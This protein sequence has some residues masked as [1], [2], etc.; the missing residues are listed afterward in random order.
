MKNIFVIVLLLLGS[1]PSQGWAEK[2]T[3]VVGVENI[4]HYPHYALKDTQWVGL[5]RDIL[6]AFAQKY[7]YTFKYTPYPLK[8]LMTYNWEQRIDLMFP[9][10]HL[11]SADQKKNA[12]IVYSDPFVD[13]VEGTMVLPGKSGKGIGQIHTLGTVLGF[14]AYSYEQYIKTGQV[15]IEYAPDTINNLKKALAERV[16]GAYL[17]VDCAHHILR[18]TLKDQ[19]TLV[20]DPTLPYDKYAYLL[21]TTKHPQLIKEFNQFIQDEHDLINRLIQQY[22]ILVIK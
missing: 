7:G 5:G 2:P 12:P 9:D 15:V 20:F 14:T 22:Q 13:V 16:D 4:D 21:S 3:Y 8:R 10:N 18:T 17:A 19:G 1:F 6:D 11:W